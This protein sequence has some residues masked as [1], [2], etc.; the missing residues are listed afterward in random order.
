MN[1]YQRKARKGKEMRLGDDYDSDCD[2]EP[3][4][5]PF[6]P[7]SSESVEVPDDEEL[8]EQAKALLATGNKVKDRVKL[9]ERGC[10]A[11]A[12]IFLEAIEFGG[13]EEEPLSARLANAM[14]AQASKPKV[15]KKPKGKNGLVC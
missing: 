5:D 8:N 10:T 13:V 6:M 12:S 2:Y 4:L 15:G 7:E 9:V 3:D 14:N 11:V 1:P